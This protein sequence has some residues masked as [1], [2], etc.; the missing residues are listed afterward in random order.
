[1]YTL[2][3][4]YLYPHFSLPSGCFPKGFPHLILSEFLVSP[5]HIMQLLSKCHYCN[6]NVIGSL[7]V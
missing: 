4:K 5:I 2:A 7:T 3:I 6:N 1:M